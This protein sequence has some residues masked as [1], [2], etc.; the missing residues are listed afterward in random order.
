M[1]WS[2]PAREQMIYATDKI[3]TCK[4]PQHSLRVAYSLLIDTLLFYLSV[5]IQL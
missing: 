5:S 4:P 3:D 1:S 2:R